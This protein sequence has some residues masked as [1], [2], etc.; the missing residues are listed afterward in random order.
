MISEE[1]WYI[2]MPDEWEEA[3]EEFDEEIDWDDASAH[4]FSRKCNIRRG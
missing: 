1:K 2:D 3:D 4:T